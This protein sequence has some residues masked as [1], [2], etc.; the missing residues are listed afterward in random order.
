[1]SENINPMELL[2]DEMDHDEIIN[3]INAIH[4]LRVVASLLTADQIK[5]QLLPYLECKYYNFCI[6]IKDFL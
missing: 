3:R 1:M 6:G 5:V 2:K 4:R